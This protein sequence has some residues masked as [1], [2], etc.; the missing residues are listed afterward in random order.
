MWEVFFRKYH[1]KDEKGR[2]VPDFFL[3]FENALYEVKARG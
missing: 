2:L 3:V 1:G